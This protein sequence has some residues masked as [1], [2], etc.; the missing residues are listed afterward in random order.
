M[1]AF[2]MLIG[3][4][5]LVPEH[6]RKSLRTAKLFKF[7]I[8]PTETCDMVDL[9]KVDKLID[10]FAMPFPITAVED[11]AGV[12]IFISDKATMHDFRADRKVIIFNYVYPDINENRDKY[13]K[14]NDS[15]DDFL[16]SGGLGLR[17]LD[18]G[19][20]T[21]AKDF[22]D[23]VGVTTVITGTVKADWIADSRQWAL[24]R[25]DIEYCA[26]HKPGVPTLVYDFVNADK[27]KNLE[28]LGDPSDMLRGSKPLIERDLGRAAITAYEEM[29]PLGNYDKVIFCDRPKFSSREEKRLPKYRKSAQRPKYTVI[30]PN[31]ARKVMQLTP[32]LPKK[33]GGRVI[34]ERRAHWRREHDHVL[35]AEKWGEKQGDVI[36][37][38]RAWI[39]SIWNGDTEAEVDGHYYKVILGD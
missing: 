39:P 34:K 5:D 28:L 9:D 21:T 15:D 27:S 10:G 2:D 33:E 16:V 29:L 31:E 4:R 18:D 7:D 25:T 30:K 12:V 3:N 6:L 20:P 14:R 1:S 11:K 38:P 23:V 19:L 32:P 13:Y 24:H 26:M 8:Y 36:K 37:M 22:E 17:P 35:R